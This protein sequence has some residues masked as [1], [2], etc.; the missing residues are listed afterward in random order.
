MSRKSKRV[1]RRRLTLAICWP[2]RRPCKKCAAIRNYRQAGAGC[3]PETAHNPNNRRMKRKICCAP[4]KR[5][6]NPVRPRNRS[7]SRTMPRTL[8]KQ[9]TRARAKFIFSSITESALIGALPLTWKSC[10]RT[11]RLS[12]RQ[13]A[14]L[15]G[16]AKSKGRQAPNKPST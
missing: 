6:R 5:V 3:M 12:P 14:A 2:V 16:L 4:A 11:K 8:V 15:L 13:F 1:F 9:R 7:N 10:S